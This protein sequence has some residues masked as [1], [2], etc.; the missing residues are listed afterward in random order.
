MLKNGG[1]DR[2]INQCQPNQTLIMYKAPP[3]QLRY[4]TKNFHVC[5]AW[6]L[7]MPTNPHKNLKVAFRAIVKECQSITNPP[8]PNHRS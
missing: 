2:R 4:A 7:L 5:Y 3:L 1:I 8:P 6:G